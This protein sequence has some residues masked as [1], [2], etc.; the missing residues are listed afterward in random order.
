MNFLSNPPVASRN[1]SPVESPGD[2]GCWHSNSLTGECYCGSPCNLNWLFWGACYSR[3]GCEESKR[4]KNQKIN[5][6]LQNSWHVTG[7]WRVKLIK[8]E[9]VKFSAM[10][11]QFSFSSGMEGSQKPCVSLNSCEK[12]LFHRKLGKVYKGGNIQSS[13]REVI[14]MKIWKKAV[15]CVWEWVY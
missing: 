2:N 10:D 1:V 14:C 7:I 4:T 8:A 12:S 11:R 13:V 6:H 3:R 15:E 5:A 9:E